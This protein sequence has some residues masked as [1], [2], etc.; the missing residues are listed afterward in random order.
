MA[1]LP[2]ETNATTPTSEEIDVTKVLTDT[3]VQHLI[4]LIKAARHLLE[5]EVTGDNI[6]DETITP[7]KLVGMII[8]GGSSTG[9]LEDLTI[10]TYSF[11]NAGSGWNTF[12]FPDAFEG[13][14]QVICSAEGEY[15]VQVQQVTTTKFQ[16]RLVKNASAALNLST[17]QYWV[18]TAKATSTGN[19]Q[20]VALVTGGSL[21]GGGSASGDS[22]RIMCVAIEFGGDK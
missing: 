5:G 10:R 17:A 15:E 20:Q 13:T 19:M 2:D 7:D 12:T 11:T 21:S 9:E 8:G 1:A 22:A 14:P 3:G 18:H 6:A 4:G 16:Y